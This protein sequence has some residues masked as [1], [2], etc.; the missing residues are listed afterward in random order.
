MLLSF[1]NLIGILDVKN[2]K[3][4]EMEFRKDMP[5]RIVARRV[6]LNGRLQQS[7]EKEFERLMTYQFRK[8][9]SPWASPMTLPKL[10]RHLFV[11]VYL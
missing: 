3:L 9:D 7:F 11:F 10:H 2:Y 1:L 8:C 4:I 5:D 6:R